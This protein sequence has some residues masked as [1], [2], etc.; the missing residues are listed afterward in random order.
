MLHQQPA[1][2]KKADADFTAAVPALDVAACRARHA[3]ARAA[4]PDTPLEWAKALLDELV[5]RCGA[6]PR[7]GDAAVLPLLAADKR[8]ALAALLGEHGDDAAVLFGMVV[9][10]IVLDRLAKTGPAG[11]VLALELLVEHQAATGQVPRRGRSGGG[12]WCSDPGSSGAAE[13]CVCGVPRRHGDVRQTAA[14]R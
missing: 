8:K 2:K 13:N 10:A 1:A 3:A 11:L 7:L 14:R 12:P 9:R 5:Q 6:M 4:F